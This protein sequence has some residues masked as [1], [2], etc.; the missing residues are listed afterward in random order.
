MNQNQTDLLEK[1]LNIEKRTGKK[2]S[3][4]MWHD[5]LTICGL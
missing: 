3:D 1:A 5:I 2:I 4:S